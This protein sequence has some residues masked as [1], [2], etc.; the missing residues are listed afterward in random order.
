ML[1]EIWK[2]GFETQKLL[3]GM[4]KN[5]EITNGVKPKTVWESYPEFNK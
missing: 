4:S 5:G 1:T 3:Q 2:S